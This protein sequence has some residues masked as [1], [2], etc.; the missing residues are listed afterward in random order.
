MLFLSA[1]FVS[2]LSSFFAKESSFLSRKINEKL[3]KT[4]S[5]LEDGSDVID[6]D[7]D[8]TDKELDPEEESESHEM[9]NLWLGT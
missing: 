3:L 8:I 9:F 6:D 4:G 1:L 7:D 2:F 5:F